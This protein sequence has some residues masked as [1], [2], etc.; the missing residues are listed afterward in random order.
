MISIIMGVYNCESTLEEAIKSII[1]QTY[2]NWEL[3]ICD[4]GSID[5]TYNIAKYFESQDPRIR[6]IRNKCNRGL[7]ASLNECLKYIN[8][9]Y[10]ARMDGDDISEKNRLEVQ[11]EFLK[12]HGEYDL[13]GTLMQSFDEKG[14]KHIIG[15]KEIPEKTDLPRFNPFHHAT[16]LMKS[17]VME[18]LQGYRIAKNTQRAEDVELWFRFYKN[19]Y[20]GYNLQVPLY[21]VR[22]DEDAYRRRKLIYS[23]QAS[24]VLY[25]GI[26]LIG[27]PCCYYIYIFK[28]VISWLLPVSIKQYW[29]KNR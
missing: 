2:T 9:D 15:I 20:R 13:V 3:I 23:I 21:R 7:A 28:P 16:I 25:Q 29:R 10:I 5:N 27:L 11:V 19:G 17:S 14:K 8:G 22:E 24:Q 12:N 18:K 6:V 26:R 1:Y 4:D